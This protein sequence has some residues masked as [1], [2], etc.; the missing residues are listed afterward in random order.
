[1]CVAKPTVPERAG[2][3][4]VL[5]KVTVT[6]SHHRSAAAALTGA[7]SVS[8]AGVD[9]GGAGGVV[10]GLPGGLVGVPGEAGGVGEVGA[11]GGAGVVGVPGAPGGGVLPGPAEVPGV[12][13]EPPG[14]VVV[15]P[16]GAE[17]PG[18]PDPAV[19]VDVLEVVDDCPAPPA[20]SGPPSC[21]NSTRPRGATFSPGPRSGPGGAA[22]TAT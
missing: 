17:P 13:A 16:P 14:P 6:R 4:P 1:M 3:V 15:A 5:V 12:P 21:W 20:T 9:A 11:P 10:P 8:R 18:V 7:D 22:P 2:V 19:P